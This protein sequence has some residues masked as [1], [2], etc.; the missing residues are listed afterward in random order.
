[1]LFLLFVIPT[2]NIMILIFLGFYLRHLQK[3][4]RSLDEKE[5]DLVKK[6]VKVD[7][8]YHQIVDSSLNQE[9]KILDDATKKASNIL[10]DTKYISDMSK[11]TID[12]A[13]QRMIEGVQQEAASSS[14]TVITKHKDYLNQ[15][16]GKSLVNFQNITKQFELDMQK[17]MQNYRE[18][19]L[20]NLQKEIASYKEQKIREADK[21]V[22]AIIKDVSQKVLNKA[23]PLDDH[24][25]LIIESLNKA[26][27]EG[28][29]D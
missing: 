2:A 25:S 11:D 26:L 4:K 12:K 5:N 23:I 14:N 13:L 8:D 21:T 29:F 1:M 22:S 24:Q 20:P 28:I 6:E 27:K 18:T 15:L 19:I 16:S 10:T 3:E 9:R 7:S 17:Q